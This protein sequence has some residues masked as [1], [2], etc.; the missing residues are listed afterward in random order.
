[1]AA[2][3]WHAQALVS[4]EKQQQVPGR[5]PVASKSPQRFPSSSP[6]RQAGSREGQEGRH[7]VA[8]AIADLPPAGLSSPP[9]SLLAAR[10]RGEAWRVGDVSPSPAVGTPDAS[11][12]CSWR[13]RTAPPRR[14]STHPA[15]ASRCPVQ[16]SSLL[17][18]RDRTLATRYAHHATHTHSASRKGA[19]IQSRYLENPKILG[20]FKISLISQ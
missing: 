1:M 17:T 19:R 10:R 20:N 12:A 18:T 13:E 16:G 15:A 9:R 5:K 14:A 11:G 2:L 4:L 3:A 8:T 7:L 6:S